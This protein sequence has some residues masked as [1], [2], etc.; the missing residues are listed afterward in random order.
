MLPEQKLYRGLHCSLI[1]LLG[2]FIFLPTYL[3]IFS[4]R[5]SGS[6][7]FLLPECFFKTINSIM[8]LCALIPFSGSNTPHSFH[9]CAVLVMVSPLSHSPGSS[10]TSHFACSLTPEHYTPYQAV[11]SLRTHQ[12]VFCFYPFSKTFLYL[13]YTFLLYQ[14]RKL[15]LVLQKPP[16]L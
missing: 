11:N 13:K 10:P 12:A 7:S 3:S 1:L 2:H 5:P 8:S 4:L 16:T 14:H 6:F 9:E 15:L